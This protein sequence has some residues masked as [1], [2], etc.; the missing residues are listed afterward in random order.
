M[1]S[2][3]TFKFGSD[4]GGSKQ[5]KAD[6]GGAVRTRADWDRQTGG[7]QVRWEKIEADRRRT[8][9]SGEK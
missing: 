6:G 2:T 3:L 7:V 1:G 8:W 5:L 9:H 4:W